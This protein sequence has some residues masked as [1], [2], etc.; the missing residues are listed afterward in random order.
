MKFSVYPPGNSWKSSSSEGSRDMQPF[1]PDSCN[2]TALLSSDEIPKYLELLADNEVPDIRDP[3][4]IGGYE[5]PRLGQTSDKN[6]LQKGV[7]RTETSDEVAT[8]APDGSEETIS[9]KRAS[10]SSVADTGV[11]SEGPKTAKSDKFTPEIRGSLTSLSARSISSHGSS[12]SLAST[13]RP[14]SSLINSNNQ[15]TLPLKKNGNKRNS[16]ASE[17]QN[18]KNTITKL[19]RTHSILQNGKANIPLAINSALLNSLRH[20]PS[21]NEEV[22]DVATYTNINSDAVRVNG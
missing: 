20:T 19:N 21:A 12:A 7:N 15:N 2:T 8:V 16:F 18:G 10:I 22:S 13:T 9:R 1:L 11:V 17:L 5:V 4:P 14:S 6:D 3:T